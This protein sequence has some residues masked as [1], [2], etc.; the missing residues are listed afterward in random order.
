MLLF[1]TFQ[2]LFVIS[3]TLA[4][5]VRFKDPG[6]TKKMKT[7]DF[8]EILYQGIKNELDIY[9]FCFYCKSIRSATS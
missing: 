7:K 9:Y 1:I 3:I 6:R 2:T 4:L 5:I 8:Y